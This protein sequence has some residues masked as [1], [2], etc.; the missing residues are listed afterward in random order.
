MQ[1][2]ETRLNTVHVL[3]LVDIYNFPQNKYDFCFYIF[4]GVEE[5]RSDAEELGVVQRSKAQS[6]L[7]WPQVTDQTPWEQPNI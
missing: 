5:I 3:V 6:S 2:A 4:G 1:K 7:C